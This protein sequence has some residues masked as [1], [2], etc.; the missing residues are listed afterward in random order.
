MANY[1][2]GHD[3]LV[4]RTL[5]RYRIVE[6]IGVGGIGD[7]YRAQD[8]HLDREVAIKVLHPGTLADEHSRKR[9]R[10]EALI[11]SKLNHP[12][13]ATI[14]DFD[15][16]QG[17]DLLVME[18]I[19]GITLNAKLA[20]GPLP[21]TEIIAL[22]KQLAEGLS[23]AHEHSVVHRDLKPGNLRLTGD[24]RLKIL[25]FGLAKLRLP[26]TATAVTE[27][28]SK[29]DAVAGTLPYMAPE[30]L[31]GGEID[32]RTD[33]HAAGSVLYEMATGQRPFADVESSQLIGAILR[34]S[35]R[36]PT[37][38]N[39]NLSPEVER[40]IGK[41]LEKDPQNRYQSASELA[42]DLRRLAKPEVPGAI[43]EPRVWLSWRMRVL[44]SVLLV[45]VLGVTGYFVR[46]LFWPGLKPPLGKIMLAVL[47]F[48]NLSADPQQEFFSD[49]LT[50]EMIAQLGTLQPQRLGV[51]A[52]TSA[53]LYKRSTKSITQI[54]RELGVGYILEGSVRRQTGRVRVT[55]QL[56]QVRDQTDL[57]AESYEGEL[58]SVF[59]LQSDVARRVASSLAV[60]LLPAE[61]ARLAST[62]PANPEAHEAYLK[63]RYFWNKRTEADLGKAISYF[64]QA[65]TEDP[66]YALAY[67][68]LADSYHVLW[69]YGNIS[70]KDTR[71]Q[72]K[73]AALRAVQIDDTLAEA[74]TSLASITAADD[75]DFAAAERGFRR[76]LALNPN[77]ATA[78]KWYAES[79]TYVGK[80]DE[81]LIEIKKAQELDPLSPIVNVTAGEI[82]ILAQKY[83]LAVA[84]LRSVIDM[85]RNF[86]VA[87]AL[88]RDAYE[89]KHMF[90]EAIAENEAA[91]VAE[92]YPAEQARQ[93]A[94]MVR[95]AYSK[96]GEAGYWRARVQLAE[97]HMRKGG[98]INYDE[99][100]YRI[101][102]FYAHLG[103]ADSVV[104]FLEQTLERH[105]ISLAYVRTAPEFQALRSDP[106]IVKI[107]RQIRLPQ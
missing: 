96:G 10:K 15:T 37:T 54:G 100:P 64:Q 36:R 2:V 77:Y 53:M 26:V 38:L 22:G 92:G 59:G 80:F 71:D 50:E 17:V 83:D 78:H 47:P 35:P 25:D 14:H 12:N 13:I 9:F 106:R 91:I 95:D 32:A 3:A 69:V 88:L 101:A 107:M 43:A 98:V 75:W 21:E 56:I 45:A 103:D 61:Q 67:T 60:E 19:P 97:Q 105:D 102:S 63:G 6:E 7:V 94:A 79:L 99:S 16:Q 58:G 93:A 82:L 41:C 48:E 40:I 87:H 27:S 1:A 33:I 8:E 104:R 62:R 66:G 86:L 57:W 70:P 51:I 46:Q 85:E 31:L 68:G 44:A 42:V 18:H 20:K 39:T 11:L 5:G 73:A 34:R 90:P 72:A 81:A 23:A 84:Q 55:A 24:G 52:R 29:T 4:G 30:Q 89:Y 74:H 49:G 65:V 76:A 28:L